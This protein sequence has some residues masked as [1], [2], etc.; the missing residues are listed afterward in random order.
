[1]A[2][3]TVLDLSYRG[4][5]DMGLVDHYLYPHQLNTSQLVL[6]NLKCL[7]FTQK[8]GLDFLHA[9][10]DKIEVL[11][12]YPPLYVVD[13]EGLE[14]VKDAPKSLPKLRIFASSFD[15]FQWKRLTRQ[16]LTASKATLQHL[17][18]T[19]MAAIPMLITNEPCYLEAKF[20]Y[21]SHFS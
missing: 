1:M 16:V 7:R 11:I 3:V 14:I 20:L 8:F 6:P 18:L 12:A 21:N 9:N 2:N 19:G 4:P 10:A 5:Q 13:G 17:C 15:T